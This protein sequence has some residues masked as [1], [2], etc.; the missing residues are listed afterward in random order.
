MFVIFFILCLFLTGL[1]CSESIALLFLN[2]SDT[3][4]LSKKND[5]RFFDILKFQ[6]HFKIFKNR[7]HFWGGGP[8]IGSQMAYGAL[9]MRT[10]SSRTSRI[11]P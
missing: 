10:D 4:V 5:N 7:S 1:R 2:E 11:K 8:E 3:I 9:E 6:D